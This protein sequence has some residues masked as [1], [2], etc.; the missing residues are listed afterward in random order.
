MID[1]REKRKAGEKIIPYYVDQDKCNPKCDACIKLLGCPAILKKGDKAVIDAV[2][3][4]GCGICTQV[5]P[6]KAIIQE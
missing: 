6:Y 1:L 3:C 2:L 5:C 4:T